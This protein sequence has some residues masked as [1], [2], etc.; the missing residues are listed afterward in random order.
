MGKKLHAIVLATVGIGMPAYT[1]AS[2][3][4]LI[5]FYSPAQQAIE[6]SG[7]EE[8]DR[9]T[10]EQLR[11][12]GTE[13]IPSETLKKSEPVQPKPA[14]MKSAD[15][16]QKKEPAQEPKM[17]TP[18]KMEPEPV[19]EAEITN[20]MKVDHD[21]AGPYLRLDA[22]YG[23]NMDSDGTQTA[24]DFTGE[25]IDNAAIIGLGL[26]YK[27]NENFRGDVTLSYRPDADV[28]ATTAAGNTASTEVN[29]MSAMINGYWDIAKT[30]A[31][32]PYVGAGIGMAR[33]STSEQTTTGGIANE[34]GETANNFAWAL[35]AGTAVD[36]TD[37]LEADVG[38]RYMNMGDFKLQGS[39]SYDDLQA[40]EVRAGLRF[41]F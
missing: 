21:V 24:G 11:R 28:S 3:P 17:V 27:H 18:V 2:E 37:N 38:Y 29:G 8:S 15:E 7:A 32:T 14:T 25:S 33:L 10:K 41:G 4:V 26:G 1:W 39:T 35:M 13:M 23:L 36:I 31:F 6:L 5:D 34:P 16:S 22:G 20:P 19:P 12:A 30:N 40:H 9:A